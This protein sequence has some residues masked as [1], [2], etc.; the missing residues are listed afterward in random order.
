MIHE[1]THAFQQK[2]SRFFGPEDWWSMYLTDVKFRLAQE[3]EAY[4][5]QY[6][7][8]KDT[9]NRQNRKG[10]LKKISKDLSSELYGKIVSKE[11]ATDLIAEE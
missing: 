5:T 1:Q 3:L 11:E 10:L 9:Y 8:I 7:F 6:K 4:R 2:S